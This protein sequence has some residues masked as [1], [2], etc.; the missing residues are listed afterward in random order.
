MVA[1]LIA[2]RNKPWLIVRGAMATMAVMVV[3]TF[4]PID[5]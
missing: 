3:K 4:E 2:C 1:T 5:G